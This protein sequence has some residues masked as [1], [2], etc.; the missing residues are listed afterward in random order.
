MDYRTNLC[1]DDPNFA[2]L[3]S[4]LTNSAN[5]GHPKD[6]TD[7][8]S[9]VN[10]SN[11]DERISIS[12]EPIITYSPDGKKGWISIQQEIT[13]EV[14][15]VP[16]VDGCGCPPLERTQLA[17][18]FEAEDSRSSIPT[19]SWKL[20]HASSEDKLHKVYTCS[21]S[22]DVCRPQVKSVQGGRNRLQQFR[23]HATSMERK[24]CCAHKGHENRPE[25]LNVTELKRPCSVTTANFVQ[26]ISAVDYEKEANVDL[27]AETGTY[28]ASQDHFLVQDKKTSGL[29]ALRSSRG[30]E[31][32]QVGV[33]NK[34]I[35]N[36]A[37]CPME[38]L[39]NAT[40]REGAAVQ[41][42][43]L[44]DRILT[45]THSDSDAALQPPVSSR[46]PCGQT[47]THKPITDSPKSFTPTYP[48]QTEEEIRETGTATQSNI[49]TI[50]I[51]DGGELPAETTSFLTVPMR[52]DV[53]E[54]RNTRV[55][56]VPGNPGIED[57]LLLSS[58]ENLVSGKGIRATGHDT[59]KELITT[60]VDERTSGVLDQS[61]V[62]ASEQ[63]QLQQTFSESVSPGSV[64][65]NNLASGATETHP[66]SQ[67]GN[68]LSESDSSPRVQDAIGLEVDLSQISDRKESTNITQQFDPPNQRG[69]IEGKNT[70]L[71]PDTEIGTIT[72]S[73][74]SP[75]R[76]Q[77]QGL[78][79]SQVLT[80]ESDT[81]DDVRKRLNYM[82][83]GHFRLDR[84]ESPSTID[85]PSESLTENRILSTTRVKTSEKLGGHFS[86]EIPHLDN[87]EN[88]EVVVESEQAAP[89]KE[90]LQVTGIEPITNS[91][92]NASVKRN[93]NNQPAVSTKDFTSVQQSI[94]KEPQYEADL[95]QKQVTKM[96]LT[97]LI[98][99]THKATHEQIRP[100]PKQSESYDTSKE[101]SPTP[102]GCD[103]QAAPRA[104]SQEVLDLQRASQTDAINPSK[105]DVAVEGNLPHITR[106]ES[107]QLESHIQ[108]TVVTDFSLPRDIKAD[109]TYHVQQSSA[110]P[111]HPDENILRITRGLSKPQVAV[112]HEPSPEEKL[113]DTLRP[114]KRS[115][116]VEEQY[117]KYDSISTTE[118]ATKQEGN[119]I[120]SEH[121]QIPLGNHTREYEARQAKPIS[122]KNV[123]V[124]SSSAL[125]SP[126]GIQVPPFIPQQN[127]LLTHDTESCKSTSHATRSTYSS[128][129]QSPFKQ[130]ITQSTFDAI[131][132]AKGLT[133]NT[134]RPNTH[135]RNP[136]EQVIGT[137]E[138]PA[139][140]LREGANAQME[141]TELI[142][143]QRAS[144]ASKR[145]EEPE[146]EEGRETTCDRIWPTRA[147]LEQQQT[148]VTLTV[149][150]F[151]PAVELDT[152]ITPVTGINV[153]SSELH[154]AI[155][156]LEEAN[157][158]NYL[159]LISINRP[160]MT[161]Q[162][163]LPRQSNSTSLS[164]SETHNI[165]KPNVAA[166][167]EPTNA[168][169]QLDTRSPSMIGK[170]DQEESMDSKGRE[171]DTHNLNESISID[172]G[173]NQIN[174]DFPQTTDCSDEKSGQN[175]LSVERSSVAKSL[176]LV[177]K[178]LDEMQVSE[179]EAKI[180]EAQGLQIQAEMLISRL[181][182][183]SNIA[184]DL[185][186]LSREKEES[187]QTSGEPNTTGKGYSQ[188]DMILQQIMQN[189]S[190]IPSEDDELSRLDISVL[191]ELVSVEKVQGIK[192][193]A[194]MSTQVKVGHR[195]CCPPS[196]TE[197]GRVRETSKEMRGIVGHTRVI[198]D[199]HYDST[200]NTVGENKVRQT[201]QIPSTFFDV[202]VS[203]E[204]RMLSGPSDSSDNDP[205]SRTTFQQSETWKPETK[206]VSSVLQSKNFIVSTADFGETDEVTNR[207]VQT[208]LEM[209]HI[210]A[211][212]MEITGTSV[213]QSGPERTMPQDIPVITKSASGISGIVS[214]AD[215]TE[216][217][218]VDRLIETIE[219]SG[220]GVDL[221]TQSV[222]QS[223]LITTQRSP[224]ACIHGEKTEAVEEYDDSYQWVRPVDAF[225]QQTYVAGEPTGPEFRPEIETDTSDWPETRPALDRSLSSP[226][227]IRLDEETS[228]IGCLVLS[229]TNRHEMTNQPVPPGRRHSTTAS[230]M[231]NGQLNKIQNSKIQDMP[232]YEQ[233]KDKMQ[234][235]SKNLTKEGKLDQK[236]HPGVLS[237]NRLEE[238]D[239]EWNKIHA[240]DHH[241]LLLGDLSD[242][243]TKEIFNEYSLKEDR[244]G[245][246]E[247][248]SPDH[249]VLHQPVIDKRR[250]SSEKSV[251]EMQSSETMTHETKE[252][253]G[254]FMESTILVQ[255]PITHPVAVYCS[256]KSD[257]KVIECS[258]IS[259]KS[260]QQKMLSSFPQN[261][262]EPQGAVQ[263]ETIV[264]STPEKVVKMSLLHSSCTPKDMSA[265]GKAIPISFTE[266]IVTVRDQ[267]EEVI[268]TTEFPSGMSREE[269]EANGCIWLSLQDNSMTLAHS[270]T[271]LGVILSNIDEQVV[272]RQ[273]VRGSPDMKVFKS[274]QGEPGTNVEGVYDVQ[275]TTE[276]GQAE[277][278]DIHVEKVTGKTSNK[279]DRLYTDLSNK[280]PGKPVGE[281]NVEEGG[282]IPIVPVE[283][284][285][286]L[287]QEMV[288]DA[289][290]YDNSQAPKTTKPQ[291][292]RIELKSKLRKRVLNVT[293][294]HADTTN[295]GK[296]E[297]KHDRA[298]RT[299]LRMHLT[300]TRENRKTGTS[301]IQT[302]SERM[303]QQDTPVSNGRLQDTGGRSERTIKTIQPNTISNGG[304]RII[305]H[306]VNDSL[307]LPTDSG[308]DADTKWKGA[309]T[310]VESSRRRIPP[311]NTPKF[312]QEANNGEYDQMNTTTAKRADI[313]GGHK[314]R[315]D[316]QSSFRG[317]RSYS[318]RFTDPSDKI[319]KDQNVVRAEHSGRNSEAS[320]IPTRS[321]VPLQ[322]KVASTGA[323]STDRAH[324]SKTTPQ[325]IKNT[326]SKGE[327]R[328]LLEQPPFH[329]NFGRE[330]GELDRS[331]VLGISAKREK[332][333]RYDRDQE[334]PTKIGVERYQEIVCPSCG[335]V[336]QRLTSH[337]GTQ[338]YPKHYEMTERIHEFQMPVKVPYDQKAP[339]S[340]FEKPDTSGTDI[341]SE[342]LFHPEFLPLLKT[343]GKDL[344]QALYAAPN[345]LPPREMKPVLECHSE[346]QTTVSEFNKVR[347]D[348]DEKQN[349]KVISP[350]HLD[351]TSPEPTKSEASKS[352]SSTTASIFNCVPRSRTTTSWL[353]S[354][355]PNAKTQSGKFAHSM[356]SKL[357]KMGVK[358]SDKRPP[359]SE[360]GESFI[361]SKEQAIFEGKTSPI[362]P[363][364]S[365]SQAGE[366]QSRVSQSP[367]TSAVTAE[368][369]G[370]I[371]GMTVIKRGISS[372]LDESLKVSS[373]Q[374]TCG[375]VHQ[376]SLTCESLKDSLSRSSSVP[377]FSVDDPKAH[378]M[379][380]G[381]TP[382][383]QELGN[384]GSDP[385]D[386]GSLSNIKPHDL[387]MPSSF[388]RV[389][390][391]HGAQDRAQENPS[392]TPSWS[393]QAKYTCDRKAY[394]DFA[395]EQKTTA[396]PLVD[397]VVSFS[398]VVERNNTQ[399]SIPNK[400]SPTHNTKE[401]PFEHFLPKQFTN[402]VTSK[403]RYEPRLT[404]LT[405]GA[406]EEPRPDCTGTHI[407]SQTEGITEGK[408]VE[409][410]AI[411]SQWCLFETQPRDL[412]ADDASRPLEYIS[413][414]SEKPT[415]RPQD[416]FTLSDSSHKDQERARSTKI[417]H[418]VHKT[419]KE[420][421]C[422]P[423]ASTPL[424]VPASMRIKR[425]AAE[426]SSDD[427]TY[428]SNGKVSPGY[429]SEMAIQKDVI[430]ANVDYPSSC[431]DFSHDHG[432][433]RLQL[434]LEPEP[435]RSSH[436]VSGDS[437]LQNSEKPSS[438]PDPVDD[439]EVSTMSVAYSPWVSSESE[440]SP[441][442]LH[443]GTACVSPFCENLPVDSDNITKLRRSLRMK[444]AP[445]EMIQRPHSTILYEGRE[446]DETGRVLNTVECVGCGG[447]CTRGLRSPIKEQP[448][449]EMHQRKLPEPKSQR[450]CLCGRSKPQ[451]QITQRKAYANKPKYI[452]T[453]AVCLNDM[454]VGAFQMPAWNMKSPSPLVY[455]AQC[456]HDHDEIDTVEPRCRNQGRQK[457]DTVSQN[458]PCHHMYYNRTNRALHH[459][460][461][462]E[463]LTDNF[464]P[465]TRIPLCKHKK[466]I[467]AERI[468]PLPPIT[469]AH[470]MLPSS[471][472]KH[473]FGKEARFQD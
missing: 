274:V 397:K 472:Q 365:I 240:H 168:E 115:A 9:I 277:K 470:T 225:L 352:A 405:H 12:P 312:T 228:V 473:I 22:V 213:T 48:V 192:N 299:T 103:E 24:C 327:S 371:N 120:H 348:Q 332:L 77:A 222:D 296:I 336:I 106:T 25:K 358:V 111:T 445:D 419:P 283:V 252:V 270:V 95:Q 359:H 16:E 41:P 170:L 34:F 380:T 132:V 59:S 211:Q 96:D 20:M 147:M 415:D 51:N 320:P 304:P 69:L 141:Q 64:I 266:L 426:E 287:K 128:Q 442:Q 5:V 456:L 90:Q 50:R 398:C 110:V 26:D 72:N 434:C 197:T 318:G 15:C 133:G 200:G 195:E 466:P 282:Q 410:H 109:P 52:T 182:T 166:F 250:L 261:E 223:D 376:Q 290:S 364:S 14:P 356:L 237:P 45:G 422:A 82:V 33:A 367:L 298:V 245:I 357:R 152:P 209:H 173:K 118:G 243:D 409:L 460:P 2:D 353:A 190:V 418:T 301:K 175:D 73:K 449:F 232:V 386:F 285:I 102:A 428:R 350:S 76:R 441:P 210:S 193:S 286:S 61:S 436:Q 127:K 18:R 406:A 343:S 462:I 446:Y 302:E 167:Y 263:E 157:V 314:H 171:K 269:I 340:P 49:P 113:H 253:K 276:I 341:L 440:S 267:S 315:I 294:L 471:K 241:E 236:D 161:D 114:M 148:A 247:Q 455:R 363:P 191:H 444:L 431:S 46:I 388:G 319:V 221:P 325:Q 246:S 123:D 383:E 339:T 119:V 234:S 235:A 385:D 135:E 458:C 239:V 180:N 87:R 300:S 196:V 58:V 378:Q 178:L 84:P 36:I 331:S 272:V 125:E 156:L 342:N 303:R 139:Q 372:H 425:L 217:C 328:N 143:T 89:M 396:N 108:M 8:V 138:H 202:D 100:P 83:K 390:L 284:H 42:L 201:E 204:I 448:K 403:D 63:S 99:A 98:N 224:T 411:E 226:P 469:K 465:A 1:A 145:Q 47:G 71:E 335:G 420:Q 21:Q 404:E 412:E 468:E 28:E 324:V 443:S 220:R 176:P 172:T 233:D 67:N 164:T 414:V 27:A 212:E 337:D 256:P 94:T 194:K 44:S 433:S 165:S 453:C 430:L 351:V 189:S 187:S 452:K 231:R 368:E 389:S 255:Q 179:R 424:F 78:R 308:A 97:D 19:D 6:E 184:W 3:F 92:I 85:V 416:V 377:I 32:D 437:P 66:N 392:F 329:T 174:P 280:L 238:M 215:M 373:E 126:N 7:D 374:P 260:D 219:N 122:Q 208:T 417:W 29:K 188:K 81:I 112:L 265:S 421:K 288:S 279:Y 149:S 62:I 218:P 183:P 467:N 401:Q 105:N 101:K 65:Q 75:T 289:K 30:N 408:A 107:N 214:K 116:L 369:K 227:I 53:M 249:T 295:V 55:P 93:I 262:L 323:Q 169:K 394:V 321:D 275:D 307:G 124:C 150:R 292:E 461:Q 199:H 333:K 130:A 291:T 158:T 362:T 391:V 379:S 216:H 177:P 361:T 57:P 74:V 281:N 151:Q 258:L 104:T 305:E 313:A 306:S 134:S 248:K 316:V 207:P 142:P 447:L 317:S 68:I 432:E 438:N 349:G 400:N 354:S 454:T 43:L 334:S 393:K 54:N 154:P 251:D 205:T 330:A 38:V 278:S 257:T 163:I 117:R 185:D 11:S 86:K 203:L 229:P 423:S 309:G 153:D 429:P 31:E 370:S 450:T 407:I 56:S 395:E 399:V 293:Q 146:A 259:D 206:S 360:D 37:P 459:M 242:R 297:E 346:E 186:K 439:F 254:S 244:G 435:G 427:Q 381:I 129:T 273:F 162:S 80:S 271:I 230:F 382:T 88:M 159:A 35:K 10:V 160:E 387:S 375:G 155:S 60:Q 355:T 79:S 457:A 264:K 144:I 4:G 326:E 121:L 17:Y 268:E 140:V 322:Y 402:S 338:Q 13:Y 366:T 451:Q 23:L 198:H 136:L 70:P 311:I 345:Y 464:F 39:G 137:I 181:S 384:R 463:Y 40:D 91:T 131:K 344:D 310:P 413:S 347:L